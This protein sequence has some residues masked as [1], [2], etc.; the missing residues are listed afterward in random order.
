MKKRLM[1]LLGAALL[2]FSLAACGGEP[3]S[4]TRTAGFSISTAEPVSVPTEKPTPTPTAEPTSAPTEKPTPAP[5]EEPTPKPTEKPTPT[6]TEKPTPKPTEKPTPKPTE[7]PTPEP[8]KKPSAQ[9]D[10]KA[11]E[12]SVTVP[13]QSETGENLVWVPTKGGKKYHSYSGCSNMI[14][15]IQ[16]SVETAVKN[17]FTPCKRCH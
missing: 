14:D 5:T 3:S 9:T 11:N 8:T 17:G 1:A 4:G 2:L 6:P 15:P 13:K 10:E 12:G 16:V 7:K